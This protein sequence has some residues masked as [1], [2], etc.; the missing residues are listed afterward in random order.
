MCRNIH[1]LYHVET[2]VSQKDINN[3]ALQF[4]RKVSGYQRPSKLN[5]AAFMAAVDEISAA[6][7][8]LLVRLEP[9]TA[10]EERNTVV[11]IRNE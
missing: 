7:S 6:T 8:R 4:V 10:L 3:A 5:E 1:T 9:N 11:D 2:P